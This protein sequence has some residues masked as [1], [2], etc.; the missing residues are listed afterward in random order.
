MIYSAEGK[1]LEEIWIKKELDIFHQK[2]LETAI[3][4]Q[5]E[6]ISEGNIKDIRYLFKLFKNELP[7]QITKIIPPPGLLKNIKRKK[8]KIN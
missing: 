1:H 3:K 5:D 2:A 4:Y 7:K 6:L 8:I